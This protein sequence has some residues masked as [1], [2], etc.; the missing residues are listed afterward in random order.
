MATISWLFFR[1]LHSMIML[2]YNPTYA[3]EINDRHVKDAGVRLLIQREDLN[4]RWVSGNKWWKLKYNL[5]EAVAKNAK[6]LITYGGA[7]SN[8]ICATAAA[9]H[10]LGLKS[11]GLIRGEQ[12]LPLNRVLAFVQANGMDLHYIP[13]SAYRNRS[14]EDNY[15]K[16]YNNYYLIPEGGS[17][18]LAVKGVK[19]FAESLTIPF[20]YLC[21]AVGTG[22]T[23]AGLIEGLPSEKKIIGLPVLKG[24]E[25]L[26]DDIKKLIV[27]NKANTNWRLI[28]D[29]HFGGYAK[30]NII[31]DHFLAEFSSLH[32]VPLDKIYTGKM[33]AGIYDLMQKGFFEQG[34]TVLAIHTGGLQF[35]K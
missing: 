1:Q 17:N 16:K 6:T 34:S 20:D 32:T 8:H 14:S 4:H 7:F 30:S 31:L 9:A 29:Y 27:D 13:R 10:E 25:F 19:E 15:L 33:M 21:C 23:L 24:A 12:T 35:V 22:G 5:A 26:V 2:K 28:L 11:V 18:A 3:E